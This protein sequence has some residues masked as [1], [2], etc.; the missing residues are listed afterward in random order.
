MDI[1]EHT[2]WI[3]IRDDEFET[4]QPITIDEETWIHSIAKFLTTREALRLRAVAN[5]F[6]N[7]Y[8][9]GEYGPLLFFLS[10]IELESRDCDREFDDIRVP[11]ENMKTCP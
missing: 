1:I 11:G 10:R 4:G 5:T 8:I 9:C 2:N 7:D 3:M 6:N